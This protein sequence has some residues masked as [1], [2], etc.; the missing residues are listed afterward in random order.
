M[1]CECRK[2]LAGI[3]YGAATLKNSLAVPQNVK[4]RA[5]DNPEDSLP[6][7]QL[8]QIVCQFKNSHGHTST[9]CNS[10]EVETTLMP[11]TR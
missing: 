11:T 7:R 6:G 1:F 5:T 10:Q 4:P 3:K 8:R 9:V 2:L